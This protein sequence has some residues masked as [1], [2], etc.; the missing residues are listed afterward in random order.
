MSNLELLT[1]L[2][3]EGARPKRSYWARHAAPLFTSQITVL[4]EVTVLITRAQSSRGLRGLV[5]CKV[6]L[7]MS[8]IPR[9]LLI[10]QNRAEVSP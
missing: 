7:C 1:T 6:I 2:V 10:S 8:H 4:S 3:D 5:L 9:T